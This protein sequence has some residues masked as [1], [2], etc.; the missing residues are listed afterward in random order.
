MAR[1]EEFAEESWNV[2][3]GFIPFLMR[4]TVA[5]VSKEPSATQLSPVSR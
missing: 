1:R 2:G 5:L 3:S 4:L